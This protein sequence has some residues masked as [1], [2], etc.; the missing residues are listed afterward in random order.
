MSQPSRPKNRPHEAQKID[1]WIFSKT[2]CFLTKKKARSAATAR[3]AVARSATAARSAA[4]AKI[5]V[6]VRSAGPPPQPL[7]APQVKFFFKTFQIFK[8]N[9]FQKKKEKTN[10][11]KRRYGAKR[12]CE[13]RRRKRRA[14]QARAASAEGTSGGA[15]RRLAARRAATRGAN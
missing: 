8:K 11:A 1:F 15:Q 3:S 4:G 9:C 5:W 12:R 7:G 6:P 2:K 13:R 14:P 10:G